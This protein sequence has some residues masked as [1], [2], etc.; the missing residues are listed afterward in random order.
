MMKNLLYY[1][2]MV[3][4]VLLLA[5]CDTNHVDEPT[6]EEPATLKINE[7]YVQVKATG[8]NYG[9]TYTL[10]NPNSNTLEV[11]CAEDWLH[12]FDRGRG[13]LCCRC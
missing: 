2:N 7:N 9:F 3:V 1:I 10:T 8:G 12:D 4:A 6:P 13:V 11:E 5:S